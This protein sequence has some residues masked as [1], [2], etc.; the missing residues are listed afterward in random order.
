MVT[1]VLELLDGLKE[2][3]LLDRTQK[4]TCDGV[5]LE[6]GLAKDIEQRIRD[7]VKARLEAAQER[8]DLAYQSS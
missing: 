1:A 7:E 2:R 8:E 6:L 3:G 5:T 4:L